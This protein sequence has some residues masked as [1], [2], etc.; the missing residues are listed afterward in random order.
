MLDEDRE[1]R[2]IV[3]QVAAMRA[4]LS[5]VAFAL[6]SENL[7]RCAAVTDDEEREAIL[8]DLEHALL[9]L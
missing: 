7:Q 8:A 5:R 6:I 9:K 3:T 1:C 2:E 4:A